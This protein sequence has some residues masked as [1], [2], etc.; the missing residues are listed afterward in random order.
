MISRTHSLSLL[1]NFILYEKIA[2]VVRIIVLLHF[3]RLWPG[4]C[5]QDNEV[6][7]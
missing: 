5:K 6:Q 4:V 1:L 7:R 2:G 3:D